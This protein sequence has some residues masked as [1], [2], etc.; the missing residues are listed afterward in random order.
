MPVLWQMFGDAGFGL[1]HTEE[2]AFIVGNADGRLALIRWPEAGEPDT[3]RWTGPLPE[4]VVA[5]V[6]THPNWNPLPSKIDI[7]TAQRSR[8]PVY[9][10]TRTEIFQKRSADR[11]RSF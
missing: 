6:H 3:S 1:R 10:V 9:V 8:L 11:L 7:R 4:G 5:I 2:A